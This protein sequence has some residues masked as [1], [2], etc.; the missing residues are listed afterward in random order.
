MLTQL[1]S[2]STGVHTASHRTT[3]TGDP[4]LENTIAIIQSDLIPYAA[5]YEILSTEPQFVCWITPP[6][7]DNS[8]RTTRNPSLS[9]IP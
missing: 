5:P 9:F 8:C 2:F 3:K 6:A 7:C 1:S 4:V